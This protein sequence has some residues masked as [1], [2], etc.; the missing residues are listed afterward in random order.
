[1]YDPAGIAHLYLL[2]LV[3]LLYPVARG[4]QYRQ[5]ERSA[6]TKFRGVTQYVLYVQV[7]YCQY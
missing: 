7:P 4:T 2:D 6:R 3:R 5:F 1:M